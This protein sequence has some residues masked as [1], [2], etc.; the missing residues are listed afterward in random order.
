M[1]KPPTV[2]Q[3]LYDDYPGSESREHWLAHRCARA[4]ADLDLARRVVDRYTALEMRYLEIEAELAR[5]VE[6]VNIHC[7]ICTHSGVL[8]STLRSIEEKRDG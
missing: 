5:L 2:K 8:R 7:G 4:E 3:L 6:V 1:S